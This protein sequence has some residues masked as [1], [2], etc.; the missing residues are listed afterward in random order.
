MFSALSSTYKGILLAL[1]GYSS[2]AIADAC[3]KWLSQYYSIYQIITFENLLA[4]VLILVFSPLLGGVKDLLRPENRKVHIFRA[5]LNF[6]VL[7]ILTYC[8]KHFPL[9]DV[10]TMIFTKPF[11][12]VFLGLWF[13]RERPSKSQWIAILAGFTGVLIAMQP[14]SEGFDPF[15]IVPFASAGLIALLFFSARFL[16]H[17]V[18]FSIGFPPI[19]GAAL[20]S[21][22]L[23]IETFVM[24]DPGHL[25]VFLLI[26][27]AACTGITAV[28]LAF[29]T[30]AAAAVTPF[31]YVEMIWALAFGLL[32]FGDVP[33]MWMLMGAAIIIASGIYL[34][35]KERRPKSA[36]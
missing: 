15:L 35:E 24:P 21:L 11:F 22:P 23:T 14:G 31:V 2:F 20:L 3:A 32:I 30:A 34:I 13:F 10:Y 17:P 9:A 28:S 1:L 12:A 8:Y 16:A 36:G 29:R 18:P 6:I 26:G 25:P 33:N 5:I 4:M 27:L 19:V 7:T